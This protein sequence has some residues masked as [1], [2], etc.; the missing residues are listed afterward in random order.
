MWFCLWGRMSRVFIWHTV[1]FDPDDGGRRETLGLEAPLLMVQLSA[2]KRIGV[3]RSDKY[4]VD[5][6]ETRG[7]VCN[8]VLARA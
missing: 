6:A 3:G 8:V 7:S 5:W 4:E 1:V 2:A